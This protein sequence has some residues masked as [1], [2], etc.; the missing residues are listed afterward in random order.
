MVVFELNLQQ[1]L[2]LFYRPH[3]LQEIISAEVEIHVV[4]VHQRE[5]QLSLGWAHD[6]LFFFLVQELVSFLWL[7]EVVEE[8]VAVVV[9]VGGQEQFPHYYTLQ[10]KHSWLNRLH[11]IQKL[12][13]T[14]IIHSIIQLC[15]YIPLLLRFPTRIFKECI[16]YAMAMAC[17]AHL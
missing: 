12:V 2:E 10:N 16:M 9:L 8:I 14:I 7:K 15:A 17:T 11:R 13:Y 1:L 5:S 6:D 4:C 3:I